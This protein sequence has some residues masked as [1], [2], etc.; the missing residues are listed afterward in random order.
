MLHSITL[1]LIHVYQLQTLYLCHGVKGQLVFNSPGRLQLPEEK[2]YRSKEIYDAFNNIFVDIG[3]KLA[4]KIQ[5]TGKN[6]F[7]YLNQPASS[8]MYAH[9]VVPE[10]IIKIIAKFNQNKSPGHDDIGNMIVKKSS[11]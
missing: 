5:H 4:S 6:Y 10:E 3:P 1:R 8:C 11:Y 7:D 9:L 2:T